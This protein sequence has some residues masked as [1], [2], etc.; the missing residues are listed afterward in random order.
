MTSL[1]SKISSRQKNSDLF[2]HA[3]WRSGLGRLLGAL[4]GWKGV[5]AFAYHRI[6]SR[7]DWPF[8]RGLWSATPEAFDA[9]VRFLKKQVDLIG[10]RSEEHTSEL[11]SRFDL[12]C[13]LLLE[14]KKSV[15]SSSHGELQSF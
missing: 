5:L 13:R 1:I 15:R 3:L 14:K 11:Q 8:D 2:T 10:A 6:G 9:Q 12:V 7:P 4:S